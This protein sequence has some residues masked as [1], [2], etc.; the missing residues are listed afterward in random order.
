MERFI[1]KLAEKFA[2]TYMAS[3]KEKCYLVELEPIERPRISR[4]YPAWNPLVYFSAISMNPEDCT[5]YEINYL[6]IWDWDQGIDGHQWDTERT[7]LLVSGPKEGST[8]TDEYD[9]REAY[10]A[11]H[12]GA[13]T[14]RSQFCTCPSGDCGVTVYWSQGKHASYAN[15]C[16]KWFMEKF[17]EPAHK[18]EPGDYALINVGTPE[19]PKYPWLTYNHKWGPQVDSIYS[20]LKKRIWNKKTLERIERNRQYSE[21]NIEQFQDYEDIPATGQ[22]DTSTIM[23]ARKID[24]YLLQHFDDRTKEDF[25]ILKNSGIRGRELKKIMKSGIQGKELKRYVNS[26]IS[27]V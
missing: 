3:R 18:S 7:A 2:P 27:K 5:A 13:I 1:E 23:A 15:L 22:L 6:T 20:K 9:A 8:D 10:Y 17:E 21:E 4:A 26:H 25:S 24:S 12:E 16:D 14:D 11:A 19:D